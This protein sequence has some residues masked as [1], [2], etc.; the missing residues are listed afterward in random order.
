MSKERENMKREEER[1]R[2]RTDARRERLSQ[3]V[4]DLTCD[5]IELKKETGTVG[6]GMNRSNGRTE[7]LPVEQMHGAN[8]IG[9]GDKGFCHS[10]WG[11]LCHLYLSREF[12]SLFLC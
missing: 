1:C 2:C 11:A 12:P 7:C 10:I 8:T 5:T 4:T 6:R 3:E 9:K